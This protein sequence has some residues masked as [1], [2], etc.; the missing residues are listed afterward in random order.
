MADRGVGVRELA[1]QV[2]CN[3]GHLS[4]LRSGKRGPSPQIASRLDN[5]LGARG[6]LSVRED[7]IGPREDASMGVPGRSADHSQNIRSLT[8]WIAS[9][10]TTDDAI[11]QI[12]R[13]A[14]YL[15]EVHGQLPARKVLA[16]VLQ[17]HHAAQGCLQGG[18]QRLRQT[19]ELLRID[20]QLLAHACL[21]FGDLGQD[22]EA[23]EY[24]KA[25]LT[26]AQ[27]AGTS[28][29]TAWGV[30]AKTA[31]WQGRYVESAELARRGFE[32]SELSPARAELAYREANAIALFGD[33]QRARKALHLAE[34]VAEALPS[35]YGPTGSVWSF[36]A[37]RQAIFALSVAIHTKDPDS[38]FHAAAIADAGW[39]QGEPKVP[40]NW[41]QIQTGVS[42]AH[43][44][45][46]SLDAAVHYIAPVLDLPEELRISTVT[47]Y[48]QKL[49]GLLAQPRFSG[50]ETAGK[51]RDQIRDFISSSPTAIDVTDRR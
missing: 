47:G 11:E 29:S 5:I 39:K 51:L 32:A 20:S 27:E 21:L 23:A 22:P 37:G 7:E 13:A 10:N 49:D 12:D 1:R 34:K 50:S 46:G 15:S 25:S 24:G 17:A 9:S 42:I 26:L 43:L 2:P 36:P 18:R 4:Y 3:P 44:M 16:G 31:R 41:A 14:V 19:R 45:K 8:D 30:Q 6:T 48:L 28:E 40:A 38:A 33:G 35:G